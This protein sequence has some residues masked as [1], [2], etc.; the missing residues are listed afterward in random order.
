MSVAV[1]GG[2]G[3]STARRLWQWL[4]AA[5]SPRA[6]PHIGLEPQAHKVAWYR[7]VCLTGVDYFSTLAYQSG[8]AFLA[9]QFLSP[10]ATLILVLFTLC[11]ALPVYCRVATES[12]HGEGSISMFGNVMSWWWAKLSVLILL[13]FMGTDFIVT[14][15]LSA[16]D[17]AVHMTENPLFPQVLQHHDLAITLVLISILAALFLRGFHEAIGISVLL[18]AVYLTLNFIVAVRCVYEVFRHPDVVGNWT[19]AL[20]T[21]HGSVWT[22]IDV[23]ALAFPKLAL[24]LSGF[25]TG[26]A[27]MPLVK[28]APTDSYANPARRI[29]NTKKLLVTAAVVMS[30]LLILT[31]F[32][33]TLLIPADAFKTGGKANGRALA[34]LAHEYLG[35]GFGTAYD[36]S[37]ILILWFAGAS[38][39]AGIINIIPRYLPRYGMSPGW[40]NA[41][42]PLVLFNTGVAFVVTI[43]FNANVDAQAG[44]YAT[45]V[46]FLMTAAAFTVMLSAWRRGE[47]WPAAGFCV[48][49]LIFS[50]TTID[51]IIE[52]P[53]G[54]RIA[55]FFIAMTV[56][57]SLASRLWRTTELR[58]ED[59]IL[60]DKAR[61]FILQMQGVDIRILA[62]HPQTRDEAEY[63]AE[64]IEKRTT[65]HLTHDERTLILEVYV[66]DASEFTDVL[67]V[68]GVEVAGFRVLRACGSVVPNSIAA[69]LLR[70]RDMTGKVPHIY[71]HWGDKH[72]AALLFNYIVLGQGDVG[73]MTREVLRQAEPNC[74]RR[75][76]VHVAG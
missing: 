66:S 42:R 61:Q 20:F 29:A 45:G 40:V 41:I 73:G 2:L 50:Y 14:I 68:E 10:I 47:R 25:E 30:V 22:M 8:I 60:D 23:S 74:A 58:I 21:S 51:N 33:T 15:T 52:R 39:M 64:N 55:A 9:A 56:I 76:V 63:R 53:D 36:I 54:I 7:V 72:P 17:A 6:A 4:Y 67:E 43:W 18:V 32:V 5:K 35:N 71:F 3:R 57:A 49:W 26:V 46:L 62:N 38:A 19:H 1:S 70:I 44:A 27:V 28:G 59:V 75:P 13:G 11:G 37:T 48:I 34:Y 12:P 69:L 24:G 65:H 16:A 31:S